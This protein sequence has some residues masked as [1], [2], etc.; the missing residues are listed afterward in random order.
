MADASTQ[1]IDVCSKSRALFAKH[2][3][4]RPPRDPYVKARWTMSGVHAFIT[5][6]LQNIYQLADKIPKHQE[7]DFAFFVFCATQSI[8]HH[9]HLE[10]TYVLLGISLPPLLPNLVPRLEPEFK[11]EVLDEHAAFAKALTE[12]DE[13]AM[14]MMGVQKGKKY[15]L[16]VPIPNATK[17]PYDGQKIK[18][19]LETLSVPLFTHL[20]H[21]IAWLE[22]DRIRA[23]GVPLSR[24]AEIDAL[25]DQH[26]QE[27]LDA[28]SS[29]VFSLYHSP[30]YSQSPDLPWIL[31][32]V[33]VPWLMYWK[34]RRCWRWFPDYSKQPFGPV[35]QSP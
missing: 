8:E 15:G 22:P 18:R 27:E 25:I 10:E 13:Y 17:E 14:A 1:F 28:P 23:S 34:H 33:I 24:F 5:D 2:C 9:H 20:Q 3:T 6:S 30:P 19:L 35:E 26:I 11:T 31:K 16:T 4:G 29:L 12:L 32:K 21:E 7:Q